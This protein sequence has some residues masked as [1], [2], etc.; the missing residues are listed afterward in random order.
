MAIPVSFLP[1]TISLSLQL[2]SGADA[3]T[4]KEGFK[5]E[6]IFDIIFIIAGHHHVLLLWNVD[7]SVH[8]VAFVLFICYTTIYSKHQHQEIIIIIII[9]ITFII[10][11]IIIIFTAIITAIITTIIIILTL[12][13]KAINIAME[14][15]KVITV[16]RVSSVDGA[17]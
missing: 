11:I 14:Q 12:H 17:H 9:F 7:I 6:L 2:P 13:I 3:I 8:S 1:A 15:E 10:T 4:E 5:S 16:T